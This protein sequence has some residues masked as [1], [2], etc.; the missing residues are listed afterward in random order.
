M[1]TTLTA[2]VRLLFAVSLLSTAFCHAAEK[3]TQGALAIGLIATGTV[4]Q[5]VQSW[6]PLTEALSHELQRPVEIVAS[7]DYADIAKA[8]KEGR[9]Q[10]VWVSN[11]V[12]IELVEPEIMTV[13]AQMVR[14]DG[15]LGYKSLLLVPQDSPLRSVDDLVARPGAFRLAA[16]SDKSV[17]GYLVPNY[18]VFAKRKVDLAKHFSAVQRGSHRENFISLAEGKV[19]IA[20]NNTEEMPRYKAEM[21][22]KLSKVRVLWESPLIPN[23][24]ILYRKDM[25]P[26]LQQQVKRFF[27][28]YGRS[29]AEK[30]V[31]ER[32]NGL[33]GFKASGNYQLRPVVDLE[34]FEAL[35]R[36]MSSKA[37]APEAFGAEMQRLTQRASR[38]DVLMTASR[39]D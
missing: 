15:A 4:E 16:G 9:V 29:P 18:Y 35:T 12:A 39:V 11:K 22:D 31:L 10:M 14:K 24:P 20:T 33:G 2:R 1:P 19:D 5:T 30:A 7:K 27:V 36:A 21:P 26:A 38:L 8:A 6:K 37:N 28:A 25:A 3:S 23:D 32:I 17:S 13:F 34:L